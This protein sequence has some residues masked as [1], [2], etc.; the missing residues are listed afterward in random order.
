MW[1][2]LPLKFF[3]TQICFFSRSGCLSLLM[4]NCVK[5]VFFEVINSSATSRCSITQITLQY[6]VCMRTL[7]ESTHMV[8]TRT[9]S[10][11]FIFLYRTPHFR[12]PPHGISCVNIPH[13]WWNIYYP[14]IQ[15]FPNHIIIQYSAFKGAPKSS[16]S[17]QVDYSAFK[18]AQS[19]CNV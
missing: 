5:S 16:C 15:C 13:F 1:P 10:I 3:S 6:S 14:F 4:E 19:N 9:S 12:S 18:G 2:G 7:E 17:V 11:G 8:R